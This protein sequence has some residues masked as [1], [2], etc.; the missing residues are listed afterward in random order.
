MSQSLTLNRPLPPL[1]RI[2]F[3]VA[4]IVL[5]WETRRHTRTALKRLD[6]HMLRDIGL[7]P[8]EAEG[9]A[10]KPFWQA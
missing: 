5:A 3:A 9:E 2:A 8:I 1:S 7:D 4:Q 10:V 6:D